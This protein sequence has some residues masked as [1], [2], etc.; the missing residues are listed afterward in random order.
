MVRPLSHTVDPS[1]DAAALLRR[2]GFALMFFAIPLG[3]LFSRRAVVILAPLAVILLVIAAALDGSARHT[4]ERLTS[5]AASAGGIAGAVLIIWTGL[6]LTWT[7]FLPQASERFLNII[8]MSLMGLGGYLAMP[9]RMRSANLNFLPIGVSLA[10]VAG[11]ALT[12]T[13]GTSFDPAGQSL[14]RGQIV[15]N[16]LVWPTVAWLHSRGRSIEA[17]AVALTVAIGAFLAHDDL[18]LQGLAVGAIF[19]AITAVSLSIG[20]RLTAF[21]MGALLL[22]APLL[23]FALNPVAQGLFG[24]GSPLVASLDVWQKVIVNEPLRLLTGHGLE[25]ALRSKLAGILPG[26]APSGFLFE[27]WHELGLVGAVAGAVLLS[28]AAYR[29]SQEWPALAPGMM[30]TFAT[31]YTMGCLGIGTALL[32][33]FTGLILVVLIFV[34]ISRGQFSTTRPKAML[35]RLS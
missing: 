6:S 29:A 33:W 18:A 13:G 16:L 7:P 10:A 34:A 31:A 11:V 9:E 2:V 19:F 24:V 30:A 17:V 25:T 27:I 20:T 15:L 35:R 21:S 22:L 5:F 12:L 32:W 23:P 28:R 4:R 14:E 8:G 1:A 26:A 3:A